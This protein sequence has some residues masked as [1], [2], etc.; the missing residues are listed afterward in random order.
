M[1]KGFQIFARI[2]LNIVVVIFGIALILAVLIQDSQIYSLISTQVFG[3]ATVITHNDPD[4]KEDTSYFTSKWESVAQLNAANGNIALAAES[5]GAVLLKNDGALPI[6][7]GKTVSLFGASAYA[8][9]YTIGGAGRIRMEGTDEARV[10]LAQSL[11]A[12]GLTVDTAL[13]NWYQGKVDGYNPDH[14]RLEINGDG[15]NNGKNPYILEEEWNDIQSNIGATGTGNVAV[16][17]IGR[18]GTEAMS[19]ASGEGGGDL[20]MKQTDYYNHSSYTDG[21]YLQLNDKERGILEGI[22]ADSR[23]DS[24]VLLI[25]SAS[26]VELRLLNEDA[27]KYGVNA[28]MWVGNYG[29]AGIWAVGDL[30]S[31]AVTPSGRLSDTW[32]A[33]N[34]YNPV[35]NNWAQTNVVYQEDIYLGYK[36][37]ETRYEDIVLGQGNAQDFGTLHYSGGAEIAERPAGYSDVVMYPFGYGLSYT[38]FSYSGLTVE[39]HEEENTVMGPAGYEEKYSDYYDV[40]VTVTNDGDVAGKEAVQIYAQKP[41]TAGGTEKAAVELVGF[42]KT[43]KLDPGAGETV[44]VYVPRYYLAE[45]SDAATHTVGEESLTGSFVLDGGDYYLT[46]AKDSHN[47]I[48]NILAAKSLSAEQAERMVGEGNADLVYKIAEETADAETYGVSHNTGYKVQNLFD[49]VDYKKTHTG[50]DSWDYLSREHWDSFEFAYTSTYQ[51][52]NGSLTR[53]YTSRKVTDNNGGLSSGEKPE[54]TSTGDRPTY[55]AAGGLSLIDLRVQ[56]RDAD[57]D[58]VPDTDE[59]GNVI[60][61]EIPYD[62]PQW[63]KL[64]DQLTFEEI[65]R[66]V[67]NGL[68]HTEAIPGIAK[69]DTVDH[70]GN[71]GFSQHFSGGPED[72]QKG[73]HNKGLAIKINDPDMDAYPTGYPCEGIIASTFNQKLIYTV[74]TAIGEDSLWS[75]QTGLYG[76]GLNMHR[77]PYH[78]RYAEYYS[79]DPV[80]TGIAAGYETA[81]AV[82]YGVMVYNKHLVL[83]DM[84]TNRMGTPTWT[85]EHNLRMNYLRPFEIASNLCNGRMNVMTAFNGVGSVWSGGQYNLCTEWLRHETGMNG[86]AVTDWFSGALSMQSGIMAG[87]DLPDG[88]S[89]ELST[90]NDGKH[91]NYEWAM[92]ESAH[93]ILY[94]VAH[95]NAMNGIGTG[96]WIEVIQPEWLSMANTLLN[97]VWII[98]GCVAGVVLLACAMRVIAL[99]RRHKQEYPFRKRR[100]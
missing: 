17:A 74:G 34:A 87:N 22:C 10:K 8:P 85:T 95:S 26:P 21:D 20:S 12:A 48:N 66:L 50:A 71:N 55:G 76:F 92:R 84:D 56:P 36:Y 80:L 23:F 42:A 64:L 11:T 37:T 62:D 38:T 100:R 65:N 63:D 93:R 99:Y 39:Y 28:V 19:S 45:Y 43:S 31:G 77:S 14:W 25:N 79:E 18:A 68:R 82:S 5:E 61:E 58:G 16:M 9:V 60:Y 88:S 7:A 75:G 47:A 54:G 94:M 53:V 90:F 52:E 4:K 27:E 67:T 51:R 97:T 35:H 83:N 2:L 1:T 91:I 13:A 15:L 40:S 41:Y 98:T 73:S 49:N 32:F 3:G 44:H 33:D 89:A 29:S 59:N 6:A 70:N 30:L 69:P 57:G 86:F 78:C 46:A 72:P 24:V 96:T 81:G